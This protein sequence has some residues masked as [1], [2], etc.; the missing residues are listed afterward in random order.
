MPPKTKTAIYHC[1]KQDHHLDKI[2]D[3]KLIAESQA[4]LDRGAPVRLQTS[5]GSVNRST[6]A[7]L[8]GEVAKR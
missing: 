5:I 2:L 3:R 4:A 8:S 1:E 6:G 7:M